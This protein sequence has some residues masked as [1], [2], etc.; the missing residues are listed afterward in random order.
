MLLPLIFPIIILAQTEFYL[1]T[2]RAPYF[3]N[4]TVRKDSLPVLCEIAST[5]TIYGIVWN[6]DSLAW[7]THDGY[8]RISGLIQLEIDGESPV[9]WGSPI[10][11]H[12]LDTLEHTITATY[13]EFPSVSF[14]YK[15]RNKL[16]FLI[17][18]RNEEIFVSDSIHMLI[19]SNLPATLN[20]LSPIPAIQ[21]E[22]TIDDSIYRA[23]SR[24]KNLAIITFNNPTDTSI[25]L[26]SFNSYELHNRSSTFKMT[27]SPVLNS[28]SFLFPLAQTA[29]LAKKQTI[30][31]IDTISDTIIAVFK[32]QSDFDTLKLRY[33]TLIYTSCPTCPV[34]INKFESFHNNNIV[35]SNCP[36]KMY[37]LRGCLIK[38]Y[39]NGVNIATI[40]THSNGIY[41][42]KYDYKE[43]VPV[44]PA[45]VLE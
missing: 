1:S 26:I 45:I 25:K 6:P 31:H 40:H 30:T 43:P 39:S 34:M 9:S 35:S 17:C 13:L 42:V 21:H 14:R 19:E 27:Y 11:F 36:M 7:C 41:L 5:I 29:V 24:I 22:T 18:S 4:C 8:N 15:A 12:V 33:M 44:R 3:N 28:Y 2:Y 32:R 23:I 38:R 37:D 20:Y 10:T 16:P